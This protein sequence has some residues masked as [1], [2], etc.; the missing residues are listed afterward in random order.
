MHGHAAKYQNLMHEANTT[1]PDLRVFLE[2]RY[3]LNHSSVLTV[4]S[5]CSM[6]RRIQTLYISVHRPENSKGKKCTLPV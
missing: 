5:M 3:I 6:G 4:I 1:R 2:D